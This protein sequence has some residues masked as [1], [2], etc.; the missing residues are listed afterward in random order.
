M[1]KIIFNSSW[2]RFLP[3]LILLGLW[4]LFVTGDSERLFMF[5]SPWQVLQVAQHEILLES[6]WYD[7]GVTASEIVVGLAFGTI[8]GTFIGLVL[9]LNKRL[10][11][12]IR[13]YLTFLG[14]IQ[15]FTLAP[16]MVIWFGI[17]WGSKVAMAT[18][19]SFFVALQQAADG[20][21]ATETELTAYARSLKTKPWPL[22]RHIIL[23]NVLYWVLSGIQMNVGFATLGALVGEFIS[24]EAG[25]GHYIFSASGVYDVPRV[26][27]GVILLAIISLILRFLLTKL[28]AS[29]IPQDKRV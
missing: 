28:V 9:S 5:S 29:R 24:S 19:T 10:R 27:F 16:L 14:S 8:G 12:I 22:I 18:L 26:W 3:A 21:A 1:R 23:P 13:P 11:K 25:L 2:I 7:V 4:Q 17:G 6:V 15:I 20:A